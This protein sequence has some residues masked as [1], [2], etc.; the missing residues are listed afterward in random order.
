[1]AETERECEVAV[2]GAGYS[3]L[4]AARHLARH[5]V[6]VLVL[7]ARHRVGEDARSPR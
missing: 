3:G 2:V 6:D 4:A 5:G 1:M 7:E